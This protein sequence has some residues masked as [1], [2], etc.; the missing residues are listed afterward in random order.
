MKYFKKYSSFPKM[1]F[2]SMQ[3]DRITGLQN[4]DGPML[5]AKYRGDTAVTVQ[6]HKSPCSIVS[7][8]VRIGPSPSVIN[9]LL[10]NPWNCNLGLGNGDMRELRNCGGESIFALHHGYH[11]SGLTPSM[12]SWLVDL[13]AGYAGGSVTGYELIYGYAH[14]LDR[15]VNTG[16]PTVCGKITGGF[17]E[18]LALSCP[19]VMST[20]TCMKYNN[21]EVSHPEVTI[22]PQYNA[23]LDGYN[24]KLDIIFVPQIESHAESIICQ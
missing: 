4:C 22:V 18:P 14:S 5:V 8:L 13:N 10:T 2:V 20:P 7:H 23:E 9:T 24:Y 11:P 3:I 17:V 12:A 21:I 6:Y 15:T 19:D 1:P 16:M